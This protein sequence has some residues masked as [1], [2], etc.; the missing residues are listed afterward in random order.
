MAQKRRR[1]KKAQRKYLTLSQRSVGVIYMLL[2]ILGFF[3]L[4]YLGDLLANV[5]RLL[6][7]DL[8]LVLSVY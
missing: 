2:A 3:A 5:F 6:V 1:Q 4:G 7:G 8:S